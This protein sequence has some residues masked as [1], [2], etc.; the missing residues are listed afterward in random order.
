MLLNSHTHT[1]THTHTHTHYS[2][3]IGAEP[4]QT[5]ST[6]RKIILSHS[7]RTFEIILPLFLYI[8]SVI[9]F[10]YIV[11]LNSEISLYINLATPPVTD[12]NN[13]RTKTDIRCYTTLYTAHKSSSVWQ[14]LFIV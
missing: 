14:S 11:K 2:T 4:D 3:G 9:E 8:K 12:N 6:L 7:C 13:I 10:L 1:L 5:I